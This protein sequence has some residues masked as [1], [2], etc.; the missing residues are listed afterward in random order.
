MDIQIFSYQGKSYRVSDQGSGQPLIFVG[1]AFQA[2]DKLG[3]L[4]EHW[5]KHY[6]LILIELPGFGESDFL[7]ENFGFDFTSDCIEHVVK[8][9]AIENPIMVGTSYGSPSVYRYV[10]THQE[11]VKA[12]VLGGSCT[13][14]DKEMEYQI[15]FMLWI[16]RS[17]KV[18]LFPKAFTEVM[19]NI[20]EDSIPNAPRIHQILAR[21][22]SRMDEEAREKFVAN[23]MR[24][25]GAKMPEFKIPVPTLVFTGEH[26]QFTRADRMSEFSKYCWDLRIVRI[27]KCDHMYHL[28]QTHATLALI[29]RFVDSISD[30]ELPLAV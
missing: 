14:I 22:L 23:S 3:P 11:H 18:G 4:A 20:K 25:I 6:R 27:P 10:G 21:S 7:P 26:D 15:R 2:L 5:S 29:D 8:T 19:C 17:Q 24:L 30:G 13:A 16:I 28:E 12:M 9:L 1:G